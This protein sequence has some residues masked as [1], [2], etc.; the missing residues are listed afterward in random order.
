MPDRVIL[1]GQVVRLEP[2]E[3]S[4]LDGLVRAASEDRCTYGY[5]WEDYRKEDDGVWR[6][7]SIRFQRLYRQEL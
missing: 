5:Y 1:A 3:P 4:H 6:I 2:L 7:S